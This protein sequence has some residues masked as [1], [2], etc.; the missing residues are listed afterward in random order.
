M[1][2][3]P[4]R[5]L[6]LLLLLCAINF[7]WG[8]SWVVSKLALEEMSPLQL[9]GWRML[10]AGLVLSPWLARAL[11]SGE[12]KPAELPGLAVLG[13][14]AFVAAKALGYWGVNLSSGLNASLL[15]ALE[16]LLTMVLARMWLAE[17]L[18]GRK[19]WALLLGGGGAYLVIARGL[20]LPDF[21]AAGV[22]GD[23]VFTMGLGLEALYSVWGKAALR[24]HSPLTVSAATIV[25][26]G[27]LW[28]PVI[29]L[30]GWQN[31]WPTPSW[32]GAGAVLFLSVGCTVVAYMS[33]LYALKTMEAGT[34]GLTLLLQPLFGAA[35]SALVLGDS[36]PP[37]A[38]AG[39]GLV[40]ASLY[41]VVRAP[42]RE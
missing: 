32:G 26:A 22:I 9:G 25:T 1:S 14:V 18:T 33:W 39:G 4:W 6:S 36:L 30:D 28:I 27:L 5:Q 41:L 34:V 19:L 13:F 15:M 17:T 3:H 16:P 21:S 29:V 7:M 37:A 40:V 11:R 10:V 35:L 12:L 42:A 31:G 38:A 24:R 2:R 23:L 8:G 20:R